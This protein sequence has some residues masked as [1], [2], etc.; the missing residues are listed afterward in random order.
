MPFSF[1]LDSLGFCGNL[2]QDKPCHLEA[3]RRKKMAEKG[4]EKAKESKD[5]NSK[6]PKSVFLSKA[7]VPA[8]ADSNSEVESYEPRAYVVTVT[9]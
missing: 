2:L 8:A 1:L 5:N 4:F 7:S 3:D 9:Q 6:A